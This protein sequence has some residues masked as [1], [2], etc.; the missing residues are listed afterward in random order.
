[1][2]CDIQT[3]K[4]IR[5]MRECIVSDCREATLKYPIQMNHH[6]VSNINVLDA[7]LTTLLLYKTVVLGQQDMR[8]II[9][10]ESL[11]T[12]NNTLTVGVKCSIILVLK[13]SCARTI[14]IISGSRCTYFI[15]VQDSS[16]ESLVTYTTPWNNELYNK[17]DVK[18]DGALLQL[19]LWYFVHVTGTWYSIPL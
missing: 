12:A 11:S 18:G 19:L 2:R 9:S 17:H 7:A 15:L 5:A 1:M 6:F 4:K 3:W 10:Y 14:P 13:K 8:L 16:L